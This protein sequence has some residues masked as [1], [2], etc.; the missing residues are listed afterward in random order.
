[1]VDIPYNE[2][3]EIRAGDTISWKK[4]IIDYP[5]SDG[6]TLNYALRN[7]TTKISF[8]AATSDSDYLV[9]ITSA[10]SAAYTIG[11]YDWISYVMRGTGPSLE[12][13]TINRGSFTILPNLSADAVYDARSDA[14]KIY[15]N[16]LAN[17]KT[18]AAGVPQVQSYTING[19]TTMY[20]K[21]AE[22]LAALKFWTAKVAA[23][24]N[25][26]DIDNNKPTKNRV[27]AR[28]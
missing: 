20:Y 12:Q 11:R 27:L 13:H 28:L 24:E 23:E 17:Y 16:L 15:D 5:S 6:W 8:A 2:P 4:T 18:L 9:T 7:A 3:N 19:R 1:M 22:M 21:P 10:T 14:R 26:E 25:A